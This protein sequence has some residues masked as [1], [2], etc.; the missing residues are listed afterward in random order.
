MYV[1]SYIPMVPTGKVSIKM[2][3]VIIKMLA[4]NTVKRSRFFSQIPLAAAE[5]YIEDAIMSE[6]PV[7]L[8]ECI[9]T[10]MIVRTPEIAQITSKV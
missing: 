2:R 9:S 1:R 4:N 8:P 3:Q 10:K 6:T 7:P 5:L